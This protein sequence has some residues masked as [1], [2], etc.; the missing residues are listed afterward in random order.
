M[1]DACRCQIS[2][3]GCSW[4]QQDEL[5]S[6][7]MEHFTSA[8]GSGLG[9][10]LGLEDASAQATPSIIPSRDFAAFLSTHLGWGDAQPQEQQGK[11][12]Q[13]AVANFEHAEAVNEHLGH[14]GGFGPG[15]V[16]I[17]SKSASVTFQVRQTIM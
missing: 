14:A 8:Q 3:Y 7:R 9:T 2:P 5:V 13:E 12:D 4:Y 6:V 1:S 17:T 15:L 16:T 11:S 10:G